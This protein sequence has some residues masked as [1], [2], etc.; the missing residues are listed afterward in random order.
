MVTSHDFALPKAAA[1]K[2]NPASTVGSLVKEQ[3][4]EAVEEGE[5][6]L[7]ERNMANANANQLDQEEGGESPVRR[8]LN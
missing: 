6:I 1:L 8:S 5:M 2:L 7:E 3:M 4:E